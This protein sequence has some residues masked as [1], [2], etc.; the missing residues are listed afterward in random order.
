MNDFAPAA[1]FLIQSV[2]ITIPGLLTPGPVMAVTIERGSLSP[3]SG[4]FI[5]LGH[6]IVEI[7]VVLLIFTGPGRYADNPRVR[8]SLALAGGIFLLYMAWKTFKS[9]KKKSASRSESRNSAFTAGI[10]MTLANPFFILWWATVGSALIIRSADFG[11]TVSILF[12]V[13]HFVSNFI[14]LYFISFMSYKGHSIMGDVYRS[15]VSL[16]CGGILLFFGGYF[17]LTAIR[18]LS[19]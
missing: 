15:A 2:V 12:Y 5:T 11:I 8:F 19:V 4:A 18:I 14:W 13:L 10:I 17:L 3:H 6:G 7:P 16:I 9:R 1:V